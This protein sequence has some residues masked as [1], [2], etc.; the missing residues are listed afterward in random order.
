[1][2]AETGKQN[3]ACTE[4]QEEFCAS[5]DLSDLIDG[6]KKIEISEVFAVF[7]PSEMAWPDETRL[8]FC[9]VPE[10]AETEVLNPTQEA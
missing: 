9:P 3:G 7:P 6:Q 4:I 5:S 8:Q 2:G 10:L 1:M